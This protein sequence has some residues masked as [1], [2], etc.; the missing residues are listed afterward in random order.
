VVLLIFK[1]TGKQKN[2]VAQEI[3]CSSRRTLRIYYC[4]I[5][6]YGDAFCWLGFKKYE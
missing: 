2:F 6:D 3:R 1:L 5:I 4:E